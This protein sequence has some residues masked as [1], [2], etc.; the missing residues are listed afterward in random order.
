MGLCG[1]LKFVVGWKYFVGI[2]NGKLFA[3]GFGGLMG[4]YVDEKMFSGGQLGLGNE[5]DFWELYEVFVLGEVKDVSCGFNYTFA[6]VD[7]YSQFI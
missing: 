6:L 7:I 2:A 5:F 1:W 3:W 4:L